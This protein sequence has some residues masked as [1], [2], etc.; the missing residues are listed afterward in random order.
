[1]P[2]HGTRCSLGT[3]AHTNL[4]T[5]PGCPKAIVPLSPVVAEGRNPLGVGPRP[6]LGPIAPTPLASPPVGLLLRGAHG[7]GGRKSPPEGENFFQ[8][9]HLPPPQPRIQKFLPAGNFFYPNPPLSPLGPH[10]P[11][12]PPP[13]APPPPPRPPQPHPTPLAPPPPQSFCGGCPGY[14]GQAWPITCPRSWGQL[15]ECRVP[16]TTAPTVR[17][18]VHMHMYRSTLIF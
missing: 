1:M 6:P 8:P 14:H 7:K 5:C 9:R 13:V 12:C 16:S 4:P 17:W 2:P 11:R 3:S 15:T 18:I 10:P